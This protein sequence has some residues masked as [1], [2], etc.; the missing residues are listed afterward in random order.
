MVGIPK[1]KRGMF[2]LLFFPAGKIN[3]KSGKR[4]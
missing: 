4:D 3:K 2:L 1:T